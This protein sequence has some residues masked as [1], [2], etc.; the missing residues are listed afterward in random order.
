MILPTMNFTSGIG[1]EIPTGLK[2]SNTMSRPYE[3][4]PGFS[5]EGWEFSHT[6]GL[7]RQALPDSNSQYTP[8]SIVVF[9]PTAALPDTFEDENAYLSLTGSSSGTPLNASTQ[10]FAIFPPDFDPSLFDD[11]L[12]YPYNGADASLDLTP[13]N[14]S[15]P[16][17]FGK[18]QPEQY[19]L[20]P[21]QSQS[22]IL[23]SPSATI[24]E[25]CRI[26]PTSSSHASSPNAKSQKHKVPTIPSRQKI[27]TSSKPPSS[28]QPSPKSPTSATSPNTSRHNHNAI[29]KKYRTSLNVKF[30]ILKEALPPKPLAEEEYETGRKTMSKADILIAAV[31]RIKE[32]E[33]TQEV[34]ETQNGKLVG[35]IED[36]EKAWTNVKGVP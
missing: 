1:T 8:R 17:D 24:E 23:N 30:Q 31:K 29:E 10:D 7:S 9:G 21:S 12:S 34:L 5:H 13:M 35:S 15:V 33:A 2:D 16:V 32:L 19:Q 3:S 14:S 4:G 27:Y 18:Y 6:T 25:V 26:F 36:W 11:W 28:T 22:P 20:S